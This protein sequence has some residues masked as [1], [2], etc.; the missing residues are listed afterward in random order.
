M[1][2]YTR[3]GD[4]GST[5]LLGGSRIPK[6][7]VRIRAIGEVDELNASIGVARLHSVG[8]SVDALLADI[9]NRL[10]DLGAGLASPPEGR[11]QAQSL[12]ETQVA[13]LER[14]IDEQTEAL[15][16]LRNFVLPGG[17]A[18]GAHLHLSR[19]VCRRAE[20]SLLDLHESEPVQPELLAYL[21]RLSDWL[22]VSART[23]NAA[24]GVSDVAWQKLEQS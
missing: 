4:K 23:A 1:K 24:Q 14:S 15:E 5:G 16:P 20:R 12:S 2:I 6:N 13:E 22:F 11:I 19:C 18:L 21:N 7:S 3:T 17:S 9:Q 10:F 8:S